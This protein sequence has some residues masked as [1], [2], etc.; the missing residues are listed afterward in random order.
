V[1]DSA[2]HRAGREPA[3]HLL[4]RSWGDSVVVSIRTEARPPRGQQVEL[5]R[6]AVGRVVVRGQRVAAAGFGIAP[7]Q[8]RALAIEIEQ[9]GL[10]PRLRGKRSYSATAAGREI[11]VAR[12]GAEGE[13]RSGGGPSS[14][15]GRRL[16]GRL[17]IASNPRSSSALIA[18]VRPAPDGPVTKPRAGRGAPVCHGLRSL[19][20]SPRVRASLPVQDPR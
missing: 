2:R 5:P 16:R 9:V 12:I 6:D 17:S 15:R 13:R 20:H 18:V 10:E 8:R 11:P 3:R 19:G 14:R 7:L 4:R 1:T